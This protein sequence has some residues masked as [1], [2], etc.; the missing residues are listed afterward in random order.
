VVECLSWDRVVAWRARRHQLHE[1][2]PADA[3]LEVVGRIT[4][5]HAQLMSSAELALWAR[6]EGVAADTVR[7]ALWQDRTLVKLWAMRGTLHLLPAAD[8]PLWQAGL[9][10]YRHYLRP[11]WFR[12][13]G[14]TP[15]E[16]EQLVAAV[17]DV[18]DG[19]ELTRE[20]LA[21]EVA[22]R[23][24]SPALGEKLR[25][26]WGALLKPVS[27]RGQLC[28]APNRVRHVSF[29]RPASWLPGLTEQ[30]PERALPE[31]ARRFLA[32]HGPATREDLARWWAVSPAQAGRMLAAL[33]EEAVQVEVDGA[34]GWWVLV[35]DL[36]ELRHAE[37]VRSVRLLPAFDQ[38]VVAA[39]KHAARLMPGDFTDRV[40]RAQGWLSPVL[41]VD[42]WMAGVWSHERRGDRVRVRLE[43]F[44]E[45]P[46]RVHRAAVAEAERLAAFLG[47]RLELDEG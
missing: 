19:R 24:G 32:A 35:A 6:V 43:P 2:A 3:A 7:R 20:E 14:V 34:P 10:T 38:Y 25:E 37:P 11:V 36:D 46:E 26:S 47:G 1:R 45:L 4:G 8:L 21:D 18:L 40:Y 9:R 5:L 42:G 17:A 27:F 41:L 33:G 29:T 23:T 44:G 30:D 15:D 13:F 22:A 16:L 12:H 39:T 31:I 28:F